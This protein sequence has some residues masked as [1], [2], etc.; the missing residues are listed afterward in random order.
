LF[1]EAAL[2]GAAFFCINGCG[3]GRINA[4]I[5]MSVK[6]PFIR[7][8]VILIPVQGREDQHGTYFWRQ[9]TYIM[10]KQFKGMLIL[11]P[12]LLAVGGAMGQ[13]I[14]NHTFQATSGTFTPVS[15]GTT[16]PVSYGSTNEGA[17]AH[18]PIGFDFT[19]SGR[20]YSSCLATTNGALVFRDTVTLFYGTG[21]LYY[22]API[23]AALADNL[24][25]ASGTFTYKSSLEGSDS[26]F[27]AEWLNAAWSN[28]AYPVM[29]FQVKLY[30]NS[31]KIVYMYRRENAGSYTGSANACIG[32]TKGGSSPAALWLNNSS[33]APVASVSAT[34]IQAH[35]ATDQVYTFTPVTTVRSGITENI[36]STSALLKATI[37]NGQTGNL[38]G[39]AVGTSANP[40]LGRAD[41]VDIGSSAGPVKG[42]YSA[43]VEG[44]IP[45]TKYYFRSYVR[46][47]TGT[48]Y[49]TLQDTFTTRPPA[50]PALKG[51]G[52][53]RTTAEVLFRGTI[54]DNGGNPVTASGVIY[55]T[56]PA[57]VLGR[58][59]VTELF[60]SP[61]ATSGLYQFTPSGFTAGTTY[62]YRFFGT[63][64]TGTSYSA[65]DSFIMFSP[66]SVFPYAENF[67]G[68]AY[69]GWTTA[70]AV[71]DWAKGTPAKTFITGG[72]YSAPYA[73]TTKLTGYYSNNH[74]GSLVS[75]V[76]DFSSMT[77]DPVLEFRHRFVFYDNFDGGIVE[78]SVNNGEWKTLDAVNGT[79][80]NFNTASS[81]A[82]YNYMAPEGSAIDGKPFFGNY[83]YYY[84]SKRSD[85]WIL[86]QSK[87]NGLAGQ[88]HVR[89]RFRVVSNGINANDGWMIDDVKVYEASSPTLAL[90]PISD[91]AS[92]TVILSGSVHSG[93]QLLSN[94]GFVVGTLPDPE[95]GGPGFVD[96]NNV[97]TILYDGIFSTEITGLSYPQK[98]YYRA[99][100]T[101]ATGISYSVTD[102][103]TTPDLPSV[104]LGSKT[105][106]SDTSASLS[107]V[108]AYTGTSGPVT[109]SGVVVSVN[110]NPAIGGAGVINIPSMP[111][112]TNETYT[113]TVTGLIRNTKHYYR[114]YARNAS[115]TVYS[116][117]DSL[118]TF[119]IPSVSIDPSYTTVDWNSAS[120]SGN[121][122]SDGRST[123]TSRGVV[124]GT[125]PNP[126]L[127]DAGVT[128]RT[129][130]G[131][132]GSFGMGVNGLTS[133]T[134]YY[135]R[136]FATNAAGTAYSSQIEFAAVGVLS[137][138]P[139][140]E[141]FETNTGNA[142]SSAAISGTNNWVLGTPAKAILNA[143]YSGV[144][145]WVTKLTG[146][147]D[148][149]TNG[150]VL[151][152][153][154][155][156]SALASDPV[157]EFR[158]RFITEASYD[159]GLVEYSVNN[160]ASWAL[161]DSVKG[162]GSNFN[163][164]K[165]TGW[166][167]DNA[168]QSR[169][170]YIP[171]FTERSTAYASASADGWI[172]SQSKLTGVAGK[173]NV[174]VR[175][176]FI[177][178]P[179]ETGEGWVIDD[180]KIYVPVA[181]SIAGVGSSDVLNTSASV[182]ARINNGG[183][184]LTA[185]GVLLSTTPDPVDGNPGVQNIAG[186]NIL[187]NDTLTVGLT[188]LNYPVKYYYKVYAVTAMGTVYS[189]QDSFTTA[190][191]PLVNRTGIMNLIDTS[192]TIRG[193]IVYTGTGVSTV[194]AS[195]V[196]LSESP[197]PVMG[198]AGVL[199]KPTS[200]V[201]TN[202]VFSVAVNGLTRSAKYYYNLYI[203]NSFGTFYS[204]QD[205][206]TT[207]GL[208]VLATDVHTDITI[209][210]INFS[211]A[212]LSRGGLAVTS[213]GV[214]LSTHR[215]P[216]KG[217]T[218]V[219]QLNTTPLVDSGT[220]TVTFISFTPYTKYFVR[221]FATNQ[222]GTT[223]TYL[224]SFIA[225]MPVAEFPYIEKF[226]GATAAAWDSRRGW[227][228]AANDWELGTPAKPG[229]DSAYSGSKAWVTK[230]SANH[231]ATGF[232]ELISPVFDFTSF[233]EDPVMS[234]QH[235]FIAKANRAGGWIEYSTDGGQNWTDMLDP[236]QGTGSNYNTPISTGWY[237]INDWGLWFSGNSNTYSSQHNGWIRSKTR[238][239]GLAGESNVR[240]KISF[241]SDGSDSV[242]QGWM[243]DDIMIFAATAPSLTSLAATS[244]S[245]SQAV[246]GGH[247]STN[248]GMHVTKSGI[249]LGTAAMP[250]PVLG[251][252][253]VADIS[254][255]AERIVTE[256][257]FTDTIT[258]LSPY[259]T[260]Y[261]R[262]YAINAIDTSY[263]NPDSFTTP[264]LAT[265]VNSGKANISYT[266]ATLKGSISADGRAAVTASGIVASTSQDPG[267][268]D[269]DAIIMYTSPVT[270][271]G[272]FQQTFTGLSHST[273]YYFRAFA[274]NMAGTSYSS[275]DSFTTLILSVPEITANGSNNITATSARLMGNIAA[276]GG[277]AITESGIIISSNPGIVL[278]ATGTTSMVTGPVVI[279][280]AFG[281]TFSGLTQYQKYYYRAY[282]I[283]SLGTGYSEEDSFM[284]IP[285]VATLPYFEDMESTS[286]N[287]WTTGGTASDWTKGTPSKTT[288]NAAHSGSSAWVTGLSANYGN[289]S[290][291][292]IV[293]P[294]FDFSSVTADPVLSFYHKFLTQAGADGGVVEVSVSG[295][296]WSMLDAVKGTGSNFN[297]AGNFSWYNENS[298]SGP[299]S[300]I[301]RFSGS[302][303]AYGSASGGWILSQSRLTGMAG[304]SHVRVRF[305]F[306]SDASV[307]DEGW[308]IDDI[309]VEEIMAPT[310]GASAITISNVRPDSLTLS[311]TNGNGEG[312][313]VVARPLAYISSAPEDWKA[314]KADNIFGAG[315]S[316]GI[317]NFVVYNGTG[318]S[319]TVAGLDSLTD[320]I[321]T[322][323]EYNGNAM[324]VKYGAGASIGGIPLPVNITSFTAKKNGANVDV[325]WTTASEMNNKGFMVERSVNG[326]LFAPW[327]FIDGANEPTTYQL[328]DNNPFVT[329]NTSEIYYRLR[330]EDNNGRRKYS[331]IVR[332]S[333]TTGL[334]RVEA[335]KLRLTIVPNPFSD[336][337]SIDLGTLK[338]D[339]AVMV[340]ITDV[341]GKEVFAGLHQRG[342]ENKVIVDQLADLRTGVYYISI[343]TGTFVQVH[344][345]VKQ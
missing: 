89:F 331:N 233:T 345:I 211:G 176:R 313:I 207:A 242:A 222:S 33:S 122:T 54:L 164:A 172:L 184:A 273:T 280:G 217:G 170:G 42:N 46:N 158:H 100:A 253:D 195:G 56:M 55:S 63:N 22:D 139:Y 212:L 292:Y 39:F 274:T 163:T 339:D 110:T 125:S 227:D 134:K 283:N 254:T 135:L 123:I 71:N 72:A 312:R 310:T 171:R 214:V 19:F 289:N 117:L 297:T 243:I 131:T 320:Y 337:L 322:V 178:D 225:V 106:L 78:V 232:S 6:F 136:V 127:G 261:Y 53:I 14:T 223:Y 198:G 332:V 146:N 81:M 208:P 317:Q 141:N 287:A 145:A 275:Q 43:A 3:A 278:G 282:A 311:W 324:H 271:M 215:N 229:F 47:L 237:N 18:I 128:V 159:G 151:S 16:V 200:P 161:L 21:A 51:E 114:F 228:D 248:G 99:F 29:S 279:S 189:A 194:T 259:T 209:T 38:A 157:L 52:L 101:N 314:Y 4:F 270:A 85:N 90:R 344:K 307:T 8:L 316:T 69:S 329:L 252:T 97:S 269:A 94:K 255:P 11:L 84:N 105:I 75:P 302:S 62:Y 120:I 70:G 206:F 107:G 182:H 169:F 201:A 179:A 17:Y 34:Y 300:G 35:P 137:G 205:S 186:G 165:S 276:S 160:G 249:V 111:V 23:L 173:A 293:S 192:A 25:M 65:T 285:P 36:Y 265:V 236:D 295:G 40:V 213:S 309:T 143:A 204:G 323:F 103:F 290:N 281:L 32:I 76:F 262:A 73:W 148:H 45:G 190:D 37:D 318:S 181:A 188:G 321:F 96:S 256:G 257:I 153:A 150:Y 27:T 126:A 210:G 155:N 185:A 66:V 260:Y 303:A 284:V 60:T 336:Q 277:S 26:V 119:N 1:A 57:P 268:T 286:S 298:A 86:S 175:F 168:Y 299:L 144:N 330:Q 113:T 124:F 118:T 30:K 267:I 266:S 92:T 83:S 219:I 109:M 288:L 44:L 333:A 202:G 13:T 177:S 315:D 112:V 108:I 326:V 162:T 338:G 28:P 291:G 15:G 334:G 88:N 294:V 240:F 132:T 41:V 77:T 244:V 304:Q 306:D 245:S 93:G 234:F 235:K 61:V 341:A 296:P 58:A 180:V 203:T 250:V 59:D 80:G 102:S 246:A 68:A 67:D 272:A 196:L 301:A 98:Y 104:T 31:G 154:F 218:G 138:F 305:R 258:G 152:P 142:W 49:S 82:W 197:N 174:R 133:Y 251:G 121:V 20:T 327:I 7:L 87:T 130:S 224:D 264:G 230:L 149:N 9:N 241:M 193:E 226:E 335:E 340:S 221:H 24:T 2:H 167:N 129:T 156:M 95:I 74:D 216:L 308:M 79:G 91:L 342:A 263:G 50:A 220:Y 325:E 48:I 328:T 319:V 166:Y 147:Y 191:A 140:S 116:K 238:L 343:S 10:K 115:G 247:I 239:T 183:N 231:S 5:L 199:N 187:K 12:L 64:V